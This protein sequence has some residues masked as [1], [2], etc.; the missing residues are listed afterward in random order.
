MQH[1]QSRIKYLNVTI[2][3]QDLVRDLNPKSQGPYPLQH[4][5]SATIDKISIIT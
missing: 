3:A 1:L 4:K 5:V 2:N